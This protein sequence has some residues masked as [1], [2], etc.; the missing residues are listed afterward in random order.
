MEIVDYTEKSLVI[1]GEKTREYKENLKELGGKFN[2][3]LKCGAGWIFPKTKKTEL[4]YLVAKAN[5]GS[6]SAKPP[7]VYKDQREPEKKVDSGYSIKK[8]ELKGKSESD[9]L[10]ILNKLEHDMDEIK[11]DI[12]LL[13]NI[14]ENSRKEIPSK[15]EEK[16]EIEY[17]E[18]EEIVE[19]EPVQPIR[20]FL[21]K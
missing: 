18:V 4:E 8:E 6:L 11:S 15:N 1:K 7:R 3:S 10:K 21:K 12:K 14:L 9:I 16:E 19:E 20:R 5:E 13:R 17:E 2:A